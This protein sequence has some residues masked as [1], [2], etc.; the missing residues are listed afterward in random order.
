MDPKTG[1]NGI[2]P[3]LISHKGVSAARLSGF[4]CSNVLITVVEK[5]NQHE[6]GFGFIFDIPHVSEINL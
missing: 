4:A 3:H 1:D 6:S 5:S 2:V